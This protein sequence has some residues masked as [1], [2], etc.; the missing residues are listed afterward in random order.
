[1]K[2]TNRDRSIDFFPAK[3]FNISD[4]L[5]PKY[6]LLAAFFLIVSGPIKSKMRSREILWLYEKSPKVKSPTVKKS[7]KKLTNPILCRDLIG[8]NSRCFN[9]CGKPSSTFQLFRTYCIIPFHVRTFC[10]C[11]NSRLCLDSTST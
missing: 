7:P 6:L 4:K 10:R 8:L 2:L 3:C 1:M 9:N 5:K 11:S